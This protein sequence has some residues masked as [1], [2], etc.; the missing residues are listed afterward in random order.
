MFFVLLI[1]SVIGLSIRESLNAFTVLHAILPL[2]LVRSPIRP[3]ALTHPVDLVVLE[4]ALVSTASA[5]YEHSLA[6]SLSVK[7]GTLIQLASAKALFALSVLCV[8]F[9]LSCVY[10]SA[11]LADELA[12]A[13]HLIVRPL[14]FVPVSV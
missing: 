7:V 2:P 10:L 6:C 4:I 11:L 3:H 8:F 5:P 14:S 13:V 1:Q 9:K 12:I